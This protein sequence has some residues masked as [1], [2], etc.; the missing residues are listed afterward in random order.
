MQQHVS[1]YFA[2]SPLPPPPP[3][4]PV[5]TLRMGSLGQNATVSENGRVTYQIKENHECSNMVAHI[6]PADTPYPGG[7]GQEVK[8]HFFRKWPRCIS[9]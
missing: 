4:P 1:K 9:N 6:L 5:P 7:W 2:R 8:I 3:P